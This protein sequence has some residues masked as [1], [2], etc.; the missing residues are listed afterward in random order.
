VVVGL[1]VVAGSIATPTA[2]ALAPTPTSIINDPA[3]WTKV[4]D[5]VWH[6]ATPPGTN[7]AFYDNNGKGATLLLDTADAS[8]PGGFFTLARINAILGAA[9]VGY[10]IGTGLDHW[11]NLSCKIASACSAPITSGN[12]QF[13]GFFATDGYNGWPQDSLF[14]SASKL[15]P[16][17]SGGSYGGIVRYWQYSGTGFG[18]CSAAELADIRGVVGGKLGSY[19]HN[20]N[21]GGSGQNQEA[22]IVTRA[23]GAAAV[24]IVGQGNPAAYPGSAIPT[25]A[26]PTSDS[27]TATK[28]RQCLLGG[29]SKYTESYPSTPGTPAADPN[30]DPGVQQ[31]AKTVDP[32]YNPAATATI[33][34]CGGLTDAGCRTA[35][36]NAGFYGTRTF[37]TRDFNGADVTR[38][39]GSV[40]TTS[41]VGGS[42]V[43]TSSPITLDENPTGEEYPILLPQPASNQTYD[44]YLSKLRAKG[45]LGT[46]T[47]IDVDPA[48]SD[49]TTGPSGI[50]RILVRVGPATAVPLPGA[51]YLPRNAWPS[52]TP[53]IAPST[54][55]QFYRNPPSAPPA[56]EPAPLPPGSPPPVAP[57]PDEPNGP[58][59]SAPALDFS[60]LKVGLGEKFPFGG[61]TY[62]KGIFSQFNS[63]GVAPSWT[64]TKP[65]GGTMTI[66]A[67]SYGYKGTSDAILKFIV[68]VG[69]IWFAATWIVGWGRGDSV[70][71]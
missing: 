23:Q 6:E 29:C 65:G 42:V 43:V 70:T 46:A 52:P 62:I 50:P 22:R 31:I 4:W 60:P 59:C 28:V 14:V 7:S 68:I 66:T 21:V 67:P 69:S 35:L 27:P 38:P 40:V 11:L 39:A 26:Q 3:N 30:T 44:D 1:S 19:V 34:D 24:N 57:P 25:P 48:F 37:T 12:Y 54:P 10:G 36:D 16:G 41:P 51:I 63:G 8:I 58:E 18:G 56:N 9:A 49:P 32:T 47:V 5:T 33:P 20:D 61:F 55:T 17:C 45:W 15:S 13:N 2:Q 53:R 64:L 71:E